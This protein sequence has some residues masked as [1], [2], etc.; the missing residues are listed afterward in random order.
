MIFYQKF[1]GIASC[2][3]SGF[4]VEKSEAILILDSFSM[5]P[6]F[7]LWK[8]VVF[9]SA[10]WCFCLGY[11]S[12]SFQS[13]NLCISL[14]GTSLELIHWSFPPFSLPLSFSGTDAVGLPELILCL[15]FFIPIF[16]FLL[17]L[18]TFLS[19]CSTLRTFKMHSFVTFLPPN[20]SSRENTDHQAT[21]LLYCLEEK[22]SLLS[23][24]SG[25]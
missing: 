16:C 21:T 23:V 18:S 15:V 2:V 6:I 13:G 1:R 14:W 22:V 9:M 5:W 19:G 24:S 8:L 10:C 4:A 20:F 7:F 12:G 25:T 3:A 17:I 11:S